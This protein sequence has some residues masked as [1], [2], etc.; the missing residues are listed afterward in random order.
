MTIKAQYIPAHYAKTKLC[1]KTI[2]KRVC[3]YVL[4]IY[5][6]DFMETRLNPI[7]DYY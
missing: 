2:K 6:Y 4:A 1:M 3:H 5:A 7:V